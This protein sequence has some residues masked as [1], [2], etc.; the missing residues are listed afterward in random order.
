M[1][2]FVLLALGSQ[3][4]KTLIISKTANKPNEISI[5]VDHRNDKKIVAGSNIDN[6][7]ISE[8]GAKT[9]TEIS[10]KSSLGVHGDPVIHCDDSGV[11][12]HVHLS[13]TPGKNW[14]EM[15]DRMVVQRSL[16]GGLTWTDGVGVGFNAD[17]MQDKPWIHSDAKMG[18]P[19]LGLVYLTWTEFD[20]YGSNDPEHRSRIR[21]SATDNR[22]MS[23]REPV[24][25]SD[26]TGDCLDGDGTLEGATACSAPN[27]TIYVVWAGQGKIWLDKSTDGGHTFGKDT[28]IGILNDG[29]SLDVPGIY[30]SNGMPFITCDPVTGIIHVVFADRLASGFIKVVTLSSYNKGMTWK[31]VEHG[32]HK[33]GDAFFPNLVTNP[34]TATTAIVYYQCVGRNKLRVEMIPIRGD[35]ILPTRIISEKFKK[36]GKKVFFGDYID[37]DYYKN[38]FI[39]G[40]TGVK[41]GKLVVRV[42]VTE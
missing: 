23:F 39:T 29:W 17:R 32:I 33:K 38:G 37:I 6:L 26:S 13:K 15:F 19:Y 2:L 1:C 40:F 25:V 18:S 34:R 41:K 22:G 12:Y 3:A 7:Y 30:R 35:E 11:F 20:R 10:Q 24:T 36:P 9:W 5:A 21:F 8:D 16:D 42:A 4:Q 31:R 27:G 28:V 14:P